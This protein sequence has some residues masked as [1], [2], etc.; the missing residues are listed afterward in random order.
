MLSKNR[1]EK[2]AAAALKS[3]SYVLFFK[4]EHNCCTLAQKKNHFLIAIS[5]KKS[6]KESS[7][8]QVVLLKLFKASK[9]FCIHIRSYFTVCFT[10]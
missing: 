8:G 4:K 2:T 6:F 9:S 10:A 5:L 1:A 7:N 3:G